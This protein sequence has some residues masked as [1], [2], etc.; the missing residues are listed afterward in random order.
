MQARFDPF[1]DRRSRD[2]RNILTES[3]VTAAEQQK[4]AL[5]QSAAHDLLVRYRD[6]MYQ[7][8]IHDRLVRYQQIWPSLAAAPADGLSR[9]MILWRRQLFFEVHAFLEAEWLKASGARRRAL[10]ALIQAA[11]VYVHREFGHNRAAARLADKALSNL[12]ACRLELT[13][14]ANLE[15]LLHALSDPKAPPPSLQTT[16][17]P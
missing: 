14:I 8:Y 4:L 13:A 10:Q 17:G 11:A 16:T 6:Q 3:L 2:I 9:A 12:T 1:A 7:D 15:E 5:V